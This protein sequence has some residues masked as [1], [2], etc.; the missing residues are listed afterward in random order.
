LEKKPL[1]VTRKE[2]ER[3]AREMKAAEYVECSAKTME[4]VK[5]AFDAAVAAAIKYQY[6]VPERKR[7]CIVV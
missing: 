7:K 3:L 6:P 4:G 5:E 1:T 2:G